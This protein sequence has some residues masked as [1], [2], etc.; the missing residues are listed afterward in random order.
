MASEATIRSTPGASASPAARHQADAWAGLRAAVMPL[1]SL[2][3]TVVLLSLGMALILSG[4]F[5]LTR[6]DMWDVVRHFFRTWFVWV[7]LQNFAPEAF[8]PS[9]PKL[10]GGFPLPGGW[11]LG[12]LMFINLVAAHSVRFT[13]QARGKRLWAGI[14][15]LVLGLGA[16]AAVILSGENKE[17][18]QTGSWIPYGVLWEAFRFG[19]LLAALAAVAAA[20]YAFRFMDRGR[21]V[22]RWSL[23]FV[24]LVF[25]SL[26]GFLFLGGDSAA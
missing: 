18:I 7:E 5:A 23:T 8:F 2:K 16:I 4:T 10:P 24:A 21:Q 3:L 20:V 22:E 6:Y 11:L 25:V 17:G 12:T 15:V 26:A 9:K 14:V 1:A 13:V 19:V